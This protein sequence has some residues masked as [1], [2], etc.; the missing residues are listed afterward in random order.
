[1]LLTISSSRFISW[2]SWDSKKFPLP[3]GR[4]SVLITTTSMNRVLGSS[5]H[6]EVVN[7]GQPEPGHVSVSFKSASPTN[8]KCASDPQVAQLSQSCPIRPKPQGFA[9]SEHDRLQCIR[10][11]GSCRWAG[12][13]PS[14]R[15]ELHGNGA[16]RQ[17]LR[18][19]QKCRGS[20]PARPEMSH[21]RGE[22]TSRGPRGFGRGVHRRQYCAAQSPVRLVNQ[23]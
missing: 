1:V 11:S 16:A 21:I 19:Q 9:H 12:T 15:V 2:P 8:W 5:T 14:H 6:S 10:H 13:N 4:V 23:A 3:F 18:L 17:P 22:D 7:T 20:F